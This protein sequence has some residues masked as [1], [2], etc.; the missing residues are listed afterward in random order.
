MPRDFEIF[1]EG[2]YTPRQAAR[3]IAST[4]Q[5]ILRWTRGSG[6]TDPLWKARYQDIE[7]TTE[8]SFLDLIEVRVVRA[9][10]KANI[11]LQSIRYAIEFAKD[12]LGV[13][14]PLSTLVF[15]TDGTQILISALEQDGEYYSLARENAGQKVFSRIVSQSIKNLEYDNGKAVRWRPHSSNSIVI[16]PKRLFGAPLLDKYGVSTRTLFDEFHY[17]QNFEYLSSIYDIPKPIIKNAIAYENS[18]EKQQDENGKRII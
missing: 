15:K 13:A 5:E 1:G 11:S 10:R 4:P 2:I 12:K 14:H 9:F 17:H 7:D 6:P 16:D 18:L 3:L 8:L